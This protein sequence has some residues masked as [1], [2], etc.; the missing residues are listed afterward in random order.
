MKNKGQVTVLCSCMISILLILTLTALEVGRIY[1][2]RLKLRAVVHSAQSCILADY[3]RELFERYHLLFMDPTYGTGSR[4]MVEEKFE[5]YLTES[6]G[7]TDITGSI[8]SFSV[9]ETALSNCKT[10]MEEHMKLLKEQILEY[11]KEEGS[12]KKIMDVGK[13]MVDNS[14][15]VKAASE[16][17]ARN[18]T[19]LPSVEAESDGETGAVDNSAE[20]TTEAEGESEKVE[21]PRDTLKQMLSMGVLALLLPEGTV[22]SDEPGDFSDAPS[23]EYTVDADKERDDGF[24]DVS[25]LVNVLSDS[26]TEDKSV[27]S[28]LGEKAAFCAYVTDHFSCQEIYKDS[29]MKCEVEYIIKGKKSDHDNL[30]AVLS[31]IIWMRMPINYVCLLQDA[32]RQSEAL[33]LAT[34]ICSSTGTMPMVEIVKYLLLGCWSYGESIYEVR[35]LMHGEK[36]PYIKTPDQ[37][38][39]DLKSLGKTGE[40]K[41]LSVGM[42]YMDYLI[43]MLAKKE[44]KD[45]VYARMLDMIQMNLRRNDSNLT[46]VNLCGEMTVQGRIRLETLFSIRN[47]PEVYNY[48][49]RETFSY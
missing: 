40:S 22:V 31:D 9:E 45:V 26:A 21:D 42:S 39:T 34:A 8:Y 36:L 35:Q 19:E 47:E 28:G 13:N 38:N 24:Q 30:E 43:V 37:W 29:V 33:T 20:G 41:S 32:A 23:K 49:Y 15:E 1:C 6:L 48:Y 11:E 46:V 4:A 18:A 27:F 17:I 7:K 10:I 44:S 25:K 12:V 5:D 16:K 2:S 3:N 14:Q